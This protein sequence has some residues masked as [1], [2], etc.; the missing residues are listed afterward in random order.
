MIPYIAAPDV[1][2]GPVRL[3]VY[4]LL[5]VA[6]MWMGYRIYLAR[7][8]RRGLPVGEGQWFFVSAV[9]AGFVGAHVVKLVVYEPDLVWAEPWRLLRVFS[10]LA[11]FG[12]FLGAVLGAW[13]YKRSR[14]IGDW[15]IAAYA[16]AAL[17]AA[18]AGWL[19]GRMACAVTHDHVG[20]LSSHWLAV[21]YPDG[22]RWNLGLVE[23][24]FMLGLVGLF[25]L[26]DRQE[27]PAGFYPAAFCFL[28]A[29]FRWWLDGLHEGVS[30]WTWYSA[31][32]LGSLLVFGCGWIA[33]LAAR[34]L[35]ERGSRWSMWGESFAD[36]GDKPRHGNDGNKKDTG[37]DQ[38]ASRPHGRNRR[39]R[40]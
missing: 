25:R 9:A 2:L 6:G 12:G 23:A 22:A 34:R 10:G 11:S 14:R 36:P 40:K 26:M 21:A 8:Q 24:L 13:A 28:Y 29:P 33:V 35:R 4:P 5:M 37:K 18:P 1:P 27:R 3:P 7:V 16:D 17:Y 38:P 32:R 31:D 19:C 39:L 15:A 30:P 20:R